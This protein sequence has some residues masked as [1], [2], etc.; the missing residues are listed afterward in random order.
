MIKSAQQILIVDDTPKNIQVL[1]QML[2]DRGYEIIVASNGNQALKVVEKVIPDLILL[3]VMMPEMDGYE[4]CQHLKNNEITKDI[5]VI[6]LTAKVETDDIVK[7]FELGAVDYV[8]KPFN[9]IEL[10]RRV[11]THLESHQ[12]SK[13]INEDAIQMKQMIHILC[14]DLANPISAISTIMDMGRD[15]LNIFKEME[16][17]LEVSLKNAI[18]II[19]DVRVLQS[20]TEGKFQANMLLHKLAPM[21]AQSVMI[22]TNKA[23]QKNIKIQTNID[24]DLSVFGDETIFVNSIFNNIL[25]NAIKFSPA[26]NTVE[27]SAS[28]KNNRTKITFIDHGVGIPDLILNDIFNV[29]KSTS[30]AGT[31]GESGT[32]FGMPL[33]KKF[34]DG[35]AGQIVI[36]SR[37][38]K[39]SGT[40]ITLDFSGCEPG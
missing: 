25:T 11:K 33:V 10:L 15:D 36:E 4:T 22:M 20:I 5:P 23:E 24:D 14:H 18:S 19:E 21:I 3:D 1:G 28:Q 26:G 13:Q 39:E 29:N 2:S 9:S 40:I 27:I 8:T 31:A 30:R 16:S 12:K 32:G 7:G 35:F 6:F 34:V 37:E 38:G 17:V